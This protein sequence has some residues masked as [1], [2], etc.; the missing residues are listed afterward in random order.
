MLTEKSTKLKG[1]YVQQLLTEA[2]FIIMSSPIKVEGTCEC[3][4]PSF[5]TL[6]MM[7]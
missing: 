2:F 4:D 1:L 6:W 7:L 5:E 3:L